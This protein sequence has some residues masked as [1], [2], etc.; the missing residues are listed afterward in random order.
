M[1]KI[2]YWLKMKFYEG[3]LSWV[4]QCHHIGEVKLFGY[5]LS[6][7]NIADGTWTNTRMKR[8]VIREKYGISENSIFTYLKLLCKSELLHKTGQGEYRV[9]K[10][11]IEHGSV[12]HSA[13]LTEN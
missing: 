3:T 12:D 5:I 10:K 11:F 1:A 6:T 9:N 8:D 2:K 13:Y 4:E 7:F